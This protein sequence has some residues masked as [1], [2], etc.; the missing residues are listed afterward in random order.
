LRSDLEIH[1]EIDSSIIVKDPIA[2]R[3]YRFTSVQ[4]SVLDLLDGNKEFEEIARFASEK[5]NLEVLPSQIKEFADKLQT[6]LLL[7]NP[8][9]WA[10]ISE[11][12]AGN[13][14]WLRSL[15][16]IKIHIFNPNELL[17]GLEKKLRFFFSSYFLALTLILAFA[18]LMITISNWNSIIFSFGK[19]FTLYSIP[20]IVLIIFVI[21]T[22]HE[23]AHGL[24]LK[25]F[26]GETKEM[27]FLFLYFI[28]AFYCNVS[29]A[30]MLRKRQRLLVTLAGSYIQLFLWALATVAWRLLSEETAA[31]RACLIT[32]GFSWVQILFN[33]IPLIRMDGYYLL[34]D[35]IEIPN[36][37]PKALGFLKKRIL[38]W[39]SGSPPENKEKI[40]RREQKI[41]L[42]YGLSSFLFSAV[43]LLIMIFRLG[44]WMIQRFQGF[45]LLLSFVLVLLIPAAAKEDMSFFTSL[46][47]SGIQRIRKTPLVLLFLI[48]AVAAG[49]LPWELKVSGDFTVMALNRISVSS[50]VEGN[51]RKIYV[52]Q[53]SRVR[54]GDALAEIE[55][56]DVTNNYQE[57]VGELAARRASLDLLK[58]G[59][60]PEEIDRAQKLIETKRTELKNSTRIQQSRQLLF[61]TAAK[62]AAELENARL[63]YERTK[64][65]LAN[66]LVALN[67]ADRDRTAYE[68]QQRELQEVKGQLAVLE[69]QTSRDQDVKRKELAHAESELRILLAGSRKE[70][71][72]E[73]ESEVK[74]LEQKQSILNKQLELMTVRSPI[75]G[76]V[77]S[78]YLHNRIG[79][80]LDKNAVFCEIV[81]EG[82]VTVE[83]AVP[84]KELD[85]VRIGLPINM[86]LRGYPKQ[87]YLAH[88]RYIAPVA[89]GTGLE[90]TVMVQGELENKDGHFKTGMTGVGKILCGKR[91]IFEIVTRRAVRWLRTEFWEYLP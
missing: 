73:L 48:L 2:N 19:L 78:P 10:K 55:N 61:E 65:L 91:K 41:F 3:F 59:S 89:G 27:G 4:A 83:M 8:F 32:I 20:L 84:E 60:R 57:T 16:S 34:S 23:F 14:S 11:S 70:S 12:R 21:M 39:I 47:K 54:K 75:D 62:K 7:D 6:L 36:L 43:L 58:A 80:Y 81:S 1:R 63:N 68:V 52:D 50:Q 69:E 77:A 38:G 9:C 33:L 42:Y 72:R 56:L 46:A 28:P 74:K 26:G 66:G 37:R 67:E 18:A 76:I 79:D 40:N 17:I 31:S 22:A 87:S 30:W 86:K 25:H 90:K 64:S 5:H 53:G 51:L 24:T 71:I 85:V 45:G 13:Q 88:I 35:I 49:F 29:D 82:L 44:G 15:L